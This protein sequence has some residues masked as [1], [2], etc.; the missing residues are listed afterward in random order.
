MQV[1]ALVE[2]LPDID[3]VEGDPFNSHPTDRA[4][5][6]PE[7]LQRF[8]SGEK[9]PAGRMRTPLVELPLGATEDRICGT[10]NIEKAL[11]EGKTDTTVTPSRTALSIPHTLLTPCLPPTSVPA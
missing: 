11:T 2:V 4:L 10:I 1:R 7:A 9:L 5:M 6:G 8:T 3:V